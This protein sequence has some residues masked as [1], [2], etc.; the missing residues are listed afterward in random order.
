MAASTFGLH[1]AAPD[2][3]DIA[4]NF[5]RFLI[6]GKDFPSASTGQDKTILTFGTKHK[7]GALATAINVF[8]K[9]D[10]NIHALESFPDKLEA[11]GYNFYVEV[12]GHPNDHSF[13]L[14]LAELCSV[15]SFVNIIGGFPAASR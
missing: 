7:S 10:L 2:V 6:L 1:T 12:A 4:S 15:T 5:T 11:F 8:A 14:A 3:Q 13:A 9:Y